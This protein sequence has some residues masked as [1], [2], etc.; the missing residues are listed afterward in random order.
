MSLFLCTR[1]TRVDADGERFDVDMVI[2]FRVVSYS[3]GRP[4]CRYQRN[5]DP[6][7]PA[8]DASYEF[9]VTTIE[10]DNPVGIGNVPPDDAP[11]PLT[12][13][14]DAMLRAWFDA[15][16]DLA[17]QVAVDQHDDGPDP[18]RAYDERRD[19]EMEQWHGPEDYRRAAE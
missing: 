12:D 14:E 8:E 15:H 3:P 2:N 6:G 11:H 5:G 7:W 18:D 17:W 4:E 19:R 9:E 10:F 1:M 16:Y 13:D